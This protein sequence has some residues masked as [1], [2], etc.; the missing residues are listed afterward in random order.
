[1]ERTG[2]ASRDL[3]TG[4]SALVLDSKK[5]TTKV[6]VP[7]FFKKMYSTQIHQLVFF[8]SLVEGGAYLRVR[9]SL[10]G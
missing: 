2:D 5:I 10:V 7:L 6:S 4:G 8:A 3:G 1:M 9:F